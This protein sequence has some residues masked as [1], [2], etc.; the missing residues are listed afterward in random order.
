[1]VGVDAEPHLDRDRH[2]R[3][4]GF[5]GR[6]TMSPNRP[7]LNGIAAPPPLRVTLGTG[8]PK[9]RS[10]WSARSSSTDHPHRRADD[11]GIDAVQLQAARRLVRREPDQT[12]RLRMTL[13]ERAGRDHLAHEQ[14][15]TVG[16]T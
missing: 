8:Q 4:G 9:L 11:R 15:A 5:D 6:G 7:M 10:M 13:D 3:R 2:R 16:A 12:Q 1:M 14:T